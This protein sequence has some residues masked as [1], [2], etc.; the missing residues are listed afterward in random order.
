MSDATDQ[1]HGT[2][3]PQTTGTPDST[4]GYVLGAIKDALR[5]ITHLQ[6][7]TLVGDPEVV[8]GEGI[9]S[10]AFRV[11]EGARAEFSVLA[12]NIDLAL[13]DI[14]QTLS[15]RLLDPGQ[16]EV[17]KLHQEMVEKGHQ[18]VRDN[19]ALL[20]DLAKELRAMGG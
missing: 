17:L 4:S 5:S 10:V 3:G 15:P 6:V 19:L 2:R 7:A 20:K 12:T 16:A 14:T 11:P 8:A 13:G 1:P 18:I 9:D